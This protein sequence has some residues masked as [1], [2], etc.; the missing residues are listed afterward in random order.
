MVNGIKYGKESGAVNVNCST[1]NNKLVVAVEDDGLGIDEQHLNRLFER[2][3][4]VDDH[5]SR[6][7]GGSGL[8]LSIVKHLIEAHGE[9]ISVRSQKG[10]G[11]SF[12]FTL[13]KA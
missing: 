2:F 6:D 9:T 13:A 11:T 12:E 8:G 5:R 4:R 3:Y 1:L 10:K 7:E